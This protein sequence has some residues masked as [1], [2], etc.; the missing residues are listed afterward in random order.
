MVCGRSF[1]GRPRKLLDGL[2]RDSHRPANL[3]S[4]QFSFRNPAVN[5]P[6][7]DIVKYGYL[8]RFVVRTFRQIFQ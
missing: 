6:H 3:D 2:P 8:L 7:M 1:D 4:F 5:G